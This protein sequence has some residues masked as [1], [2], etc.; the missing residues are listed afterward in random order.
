MGEC[1][2]EGN[3]DQYSQGAVVC[4]NK[5]VGP[6]LSPTMFTASNGMDLFQWWKDVGPEE[7]ASE[8]EAAGR[9]EL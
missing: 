6:H 9:E 5:A 8:E 1:R 7:E 2:L 4:D 3:P